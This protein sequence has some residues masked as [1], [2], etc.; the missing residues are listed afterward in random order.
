M[1][2][3]REN[4][5]TESSF[6]LVNEVKGSL[7]SLGGGRSGESFRDLF[8]HAA[9]GYLEYDTEGRITRIHRTDL[10]MIGHPVWGFN[11]KNGTDRQQVLE[12]LAGLRPPAR[13]L[14]GSYG[15]IDG[16][17]PAIED[18]TDKTIQKS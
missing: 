5:K 3:G 1:E 8:E 7:S 10:E 15:R 18:V 9:V 14:E 13:K 4:N 6:V 17:T 2:A 11:V 12:K 16:T